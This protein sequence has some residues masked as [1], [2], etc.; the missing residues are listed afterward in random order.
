MTRRRAVLAPVFLTS[1]LLAVSAQP[2]LAQR[3]GQGADDGISTWRVVAALLL[4]LGLAVF[5][6][7]AMRSRM[8]GLPLLS[9]IRLS[10][11][12]PARRMQ[13]VE[14]LRLSHQIDLCIVACDGQQLLVA[15]STQGATLLKDLPSQTSSEQQA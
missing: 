6:A 15:A 3:L 14:T 12:R 11:V 8:G 5:A 10:G 7:Y 1:V 9:S 4:C 2:A 13:L